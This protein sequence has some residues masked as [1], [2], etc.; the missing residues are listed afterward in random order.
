MNTARLSII[1]PTYN[2]PELLHRAVSSALNQTITDIEIIVVDDCSNPAVVLPERENLRV[3][4]L[5]SNQGGAMARNRGAIESRSRWIT[6]LDD[7]D[8]L[9]PDMAQKALSAID[10]MPQNLP[11]PIAVLFGLNIVN[12][13][14]QVLET[15]LPPTLPRGSHFCLEEIQPGESF[16]CKQTLVVEREVMLE[17]GGFDPNFN[18]RVHTELFLR[19]NPVCSL[20]GIAEITY[21]LSAYEG[22]RVSS[23]AQRRQRSFEKL[24]TK[25]HALFIS[26]SRKKFADFVFNH[27]DML[28][29]NGQS[30]MAAKALGRAFL[31]HPVHTIARF[32][33]PY[34]KGLLKSFS[35]LRN[36][37]PPSIS[38]AR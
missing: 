14:G 27:A 37:V 10:Q 12:S 1:I 15:H 16:F 31:I 6:Y 29:R 36:R 26:H 24:L 25:H 18:S 3:I 13:Q 32:A 7:D 17:M 21:H 9:L 20:W 2:R 8:V 5:E 30:W 28:Q 35:S 23:N 4:R 19:L 33:S 38:N 22:V 34:K 11:A